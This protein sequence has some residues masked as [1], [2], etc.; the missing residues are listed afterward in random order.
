MPAGSFTVIGGGLEVVGD[1]G[2]T[3]VVSFRVKIDQR[4]GHG[5][6]DTGPSLRE[7]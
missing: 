2:G 3:L 4:P 1:E 5:G 7:K 6:V